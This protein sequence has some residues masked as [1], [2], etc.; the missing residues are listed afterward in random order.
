MAFGI[1]GKLADHRID[2]L[3]SEIFR[4]HFADELAIFFESGTQEA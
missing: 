1:S 4:S 2:T 3:G